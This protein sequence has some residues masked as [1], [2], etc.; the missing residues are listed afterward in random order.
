MNRLQVGDRAPSTLLINVNDQQV[1]L[2]STW[3]ETP[4]LLTFLRHFG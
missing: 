4:V 2:S 3:A 1:D